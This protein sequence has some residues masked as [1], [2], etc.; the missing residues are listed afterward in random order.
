MAPGRVRNGPHLLTVLIA[1]ALTAV[2]AANAGPPGGGKGGKPSRDRTPPVVVVSAP[3]AGSTLAAVV[4]VVG[5]ASDDRG[6]AAVALSVDGAAYSSVSGIAAWSFALDT[7][8][9]EDGGHT[10]RVR[11]TDAAGNEASTSTAVTFLNATPEPPPP[12]PDLTPPLLAVTAPAQGATVTGAVTVVGTAEDAGGVAS[13][14][15]RVDDRAFE[16]ASGTST[17]SYALETSALS[18]GSHELTVRAIDTAGNA[19][20]ARYELVVNNGAPVPPPPMPTG[21]IGGYVFEETDR[22]GVFELGERPLGGQHLFLFAGSGGYVANTYSQPGG[23]YEFRGVEPGSYRVEFAP[24]AWWTLRD[25]LVPDTTGSIFPRIAVSLD[26]A[27]RADFG[28]RAI[29]R[30]TVPDSPIS[31]YVGPSGMRVHSYDDVVSAREVHDRLL[32][33]S[34]LGAEATHVTVRFDFADAGTTS[35]MAIHD[36]AT[37]TSYSATSNITYRSWLEGEDGLFHEY[38]HAWS[39]FYAFMIHQDPSLSAYLTARGIAADPRLDTSYAWDRKELIAED[40]RQLF[41][42]ADARRSPQLNRDLPAAQDV[43]GLRAFLQD[44]FTQPAAP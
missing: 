22:D 5:T 9:Y 17:W 15:V 25:A 38:G 40:Y 24:A 43:P 3:V 42:S 27:A 13:V 32:G 1:A 16:P 10:L 33:G 28:W 30:S 37:Y 7:T 21:T 12:P 19:A 34:L 29:L 4:Q 41:G 2:G 26:G 35:T 6:V 20:T 11:A 39:L 8:Q 44:V 31:S 23:W 14:D 18:D 36:G